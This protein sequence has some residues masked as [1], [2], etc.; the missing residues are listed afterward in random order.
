MIPACITKVDIAQAMRRIKRNGVPLGRQGRNYCL[1]ANGGHLPPKYTISLAHEIAT[2]EALNSNR[3]SGGAESNNFLRRCGFKVVECVCGGSDQVASRAASVSVSGSSERARTTSTRHSERCPECKQ[4]VRELLE[5]IYGRCLPNPGF[6]WR[7]DLAPYAKTSIGTALQDV[8]TMLQTYRGFGISDFVRNKT[9][10]GCDF[11]VPDPDFIVEFDESQHFTSA[12]KLALSVYADDKPLGF[13]AKRWITLCEKHNAKDND[14][15]FRD[16]QRAWYDTLRDLVPSIKGLRPTVR[17]YARDRVWCSL[18]PDSEEDQ[19]RFSDL[20]HQ[21]RPPSGQTTAAIR[22]SADRPTSILR[23]A[24]VFP[25]VEQRSKNGVPPSGAEAHRPKVPS[26]KQF[27]DESVDFV[28]FPE[29]YIRASDVKRKRLLQKLASDL[30]APLLVGATDNSVDPDSCRNWQV[31]LRFE[32]GGSCPCRVYVKHSTAEAV[33]FGMPEWEPHVR[34]PTF[35][36]GGVRAGATICHDHYLGLLPR[37]L[38]KNGARVWV[39]PSFDNVVDI[40][41]SSVLRLRAVENRFFALCTLHCDVTKRKRKRPRTHPFAFSPDGS[42]LSARQAGSKDVQPLSECHKPGIYIIELDMAAVDEPL[43]WSKLPNAEKQ[44]CTRKESKDSK[45]VRV[46][47]KGRRPTVF[48]CSGW[49]SGDTGSCVETDH[50]P[51]YVGV[52]PGERILDAAECFN[53]LYQARKMKCTPI[54]WNHWEQLPADSAKLATLMMGRAI[55]CCAPIVI[56]DRG[57]ICELVELSNKNKIP[58]RRKMEESGEA[59]ADIRYAWGLKS[60]FNMVEENIRPGN[61]KREA[62]KRYRSLG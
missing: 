36:L 62:L 45:L 12:R 26:R 46:K 44:K 27:A 6:G 39:N 33:A 7:T 25:P 30:D 4:R 16:E 59:I 15:P 52:V 23:V 5:R 10:A 29:G 60:A 14:P 2:G 21:G 22:S 49:K 38:G 41:W 48:G 55:E 51:V 43:D 9:L 58:A 57:G 42:E 40:K 24:M 28:L 56:S 1:V 32:P 18:D 54:I 8:A 34:L 53:V 20:M 50:G 19:K 61:K 37:F 17:L 3:F 47:L 11:W 31:L 35:E 13:S